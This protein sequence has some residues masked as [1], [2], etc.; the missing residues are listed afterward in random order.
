MGLENF[1]PE[2]KPI[3]FMSN[4]KKIEFTVRGLTLVDMTYL[5][6]THQADMESAWALFQDLRSKAQ[7][8]ATFD[9]IIISLCQDTPILV[10]EVISVAADQRELA[11]KYARL[12]FSVTALALSDIIRMSTEEAGGLKNLVGTLV[13][14]IKGVMPDETRTALESQLQALRSKGSTGVFG[15]T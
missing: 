12:P 9:S 3:S 7:A 10:A 6:G 5:I 15:P 1:E 4:G 8:Q 11:E 13:A 14:L 2:I